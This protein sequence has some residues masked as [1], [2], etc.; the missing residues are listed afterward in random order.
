MII[1]EREYS[2]ESLIDLDEHL[3]D[4]IYDESL[5]LPQDEYGFRR[6]SFSVIVVWT[7][8]DE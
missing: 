7:D 2:D 1:F 8:E 4:A 5:N 3:Q 6:G